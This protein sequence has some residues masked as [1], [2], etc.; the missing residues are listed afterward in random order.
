[1]LTVPRS[2]SSTAAQASV[3]SSTV[4]R[5][6]T[7]PRGRV[8][9][10]Q[11]KALPYVNE[12]WGDGDPQPGQIAEIPLDFRK[13]GRNAIQAAKQ[14]IIQKVREEERNRIRDE[15]EDRVGELV[16]GTVQQVDR[17]NALVFLDRRTEAIMPAR[18]Q[19]WPL[20]DFCVQVPA[21]Q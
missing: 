4:V 9:I 1:M 21:S 6:L 16:S 10:E 2:G 13:F 11:A 20:L 18:E 12:P 3:M 5:G 15:Y 8:T 14:M 17:G 19:V 7:M